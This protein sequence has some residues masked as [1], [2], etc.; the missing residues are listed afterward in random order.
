MIHCVVDAEEAVVGV[1]EL[2]DGDGAVLC[3]VSLQ[4]EG[5]LLC[6][7]AC[8]NL[9][10]HPIGAFVE[11][12]QHRIVHVVVEQDDAAFGAAHQVADESVGVEDLSVEEDALQWRQGGMDEEV[13][14]L[15]SLAY[16]LLQAFKALVDGITFEQIVFQHIVGPLAEHG[17]N[18]AVDTVANG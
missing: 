11:Q 16:T 2:I 13:D 18:D 17:G 5:E 8:V 10:A 4:V 12:G 14:F 6:D 1:L 7:V 3:I 15:F 9:C